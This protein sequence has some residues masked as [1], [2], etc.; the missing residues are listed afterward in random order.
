MEEEIKKIT[1]SL[2]FYLEQNKKLLEEN[3]EQK[4]DKASLTEKIK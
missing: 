3:K 2:D 4:D 1:G